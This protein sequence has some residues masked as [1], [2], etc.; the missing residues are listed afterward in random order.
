M[1][2]PHPPT[3]FSSPSRRGEGGPGVEERLLNTS[4]PRSKDE[5]PL[6]VPPWFSRRI[7]L[8]RLRS[9]AV[10][11][12]PRA[13]LLTVGMTRSVPTYGRFRPACSRVSFRVGG[14]D[15]F[16]RLVALCAPHPFPYL[17]LSLQVARTIPQVGAAVNRPAPRARIWACSQTRPRY[18]AL[19]QVIAFAPAHMLWFLLGGLGALPLG[20]PK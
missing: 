15:T 10:T 11:G 5:G 1:T 20:L 16:T 6:V 3:P 12:E 14:G 17:S 9:V 4:A 7:C 19:R 18:L 13:N 8:R 2:S